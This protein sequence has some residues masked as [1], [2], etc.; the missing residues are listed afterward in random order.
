Q[1]VFKAGDGPSPAETSAWVSKHD[2]AK[3][4]HVIDRL[5]DEG[6]RTI[7]KVRAFIL[8][9]YEASSSNATSVEKQGMGR[10][11]GS[12]SK[13]GSL[14]KPQGGLSEHGS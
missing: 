8:K 7:E 12:S 14:A 1:L 5:L 3:A 9:A 2:A 11:H 6:V 10:G 4:R 13:A